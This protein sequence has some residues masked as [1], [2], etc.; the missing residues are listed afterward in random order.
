[1]CPSCLNILY[2]KWVGTQQ[3]RVIKLSMKQIVV[4]E[5]SEAKK[6]PKMYEENMN[7]IQ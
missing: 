1:M 7:F 6:C 2:E 5:S 4:G 3:F